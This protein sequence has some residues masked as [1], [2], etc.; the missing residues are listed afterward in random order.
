MLGENS[1]APRHSS[2]RG[3][4]V[5]S[6]GWEVGGVYGGSVGVLRAECSAA[7]PASTCPALAQPTDPQLQLSSLTREMVTCCLPPWASLWI[8][9]FMFRKY[10]KEGVV[11]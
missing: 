6:A 11:T 7:Q 5:P 4:A 9:C 8:N 3:V 1:E 10:L 2:C